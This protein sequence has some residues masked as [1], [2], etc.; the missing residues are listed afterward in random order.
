MTVTAARQ[1]PSAAPWRPPLDPT[2]Y[3]RAALLRAQER[4]ALVV[5][6]WRAARPA[7]R[8]GPW[9]KRVRTA[10]ARL[11]APLDDVL[12]I[13]ATGRRGKRHL[14]I[15][16]IVREMQRSQATFWAW[17]P[18]AWRVVVQAADSDIRQEVLAVAYLLGGHTDL[19]AALPGF[20][21]RVFAEKLFGRE[22]VGAAVDRIRG[23]LRGWGY[24]DKLGARPAPA[25]LCDL[26]LRG[27]SPRPEDLSVD[28]VAVADAACAT[29]DLRHG[30][31]VVAR[32]LVTLG[33]L[34]A[35]PLAEQAD[36]DA[37]LA[38]AAAARADVPDA[39]ATWC[40]RW[41]RT[42]PLARKSRQAG[43]Y[44]LLKVGR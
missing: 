4:E 39:W 15:G 27:G 2:C 23:V 21:R 43:Y 11:V 33:I 13:V 3:D 22:A 30:L 16:H 14:V 18:D 8:K 5:L 7:F 40:G 38:G 42:S 31:R 29:V 24:G 6:A 34:A 20:K 35:S 28:L 19:H 36:D 10:L 41:L 32:A 1:T 9:P 17:T 12:R 44:Y 25:A 26:L 37:W